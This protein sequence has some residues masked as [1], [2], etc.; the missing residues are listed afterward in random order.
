MKRQIF[1]R[2]AS[3]AVLVSTLATGVFAADETVPE[4]VKTTDG[5]VLKLTWNDEFNGEGLPDSSKWSYEVGYIRNNEAQ[6]YTDARLENIFQKDG[7]LTIRTLK[8]DYD[9]K[10]KPNNKGRE[11]AE[12]TSAAIETLGKASWQYGRV[13]VR[14]KLPS[15]VGIWPAI[16]MM[17]DNITK[18]GWPTC[19]EIDIME[20]VG[21]T[22]RTS[23]ATIHMHRKG[24]ERWKNV[25]RGNALKF[26]KEGEAPEERFCVYALE[27]TKDY[28]KLF[29][30]LSNQIAPEPIV[31]IPKRSDAL[32][33]A[34]L[35]GR[36]FP[37]RVSPPLSLL[38]K[39]ESPAIVRKSRGILSISCRV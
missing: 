10:D 29:V 11:K 16:W 9:I 6:Y 36:S 31:D 34:K 35:R 30:S 18:V 4:T 39:K 21:H 27:W 13:E 25:S 12:Y 7:L 24:A 2:F 15:G 20:Y 22:P 38:P 23:H 37:P 14:A 17:G 33:N 19:G 1:A 5:R 28:L 26:E 3:A 32:L 8:E